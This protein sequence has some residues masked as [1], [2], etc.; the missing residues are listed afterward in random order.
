MMGKIICGGVIP[1]R[2]TENE[3]EVLLLLHK[4]GDYWGFPKGRRNLGETNEETAIR[5]LFEETNLAIESLV[6]YPPIEEKFSFES[7]GVK[8]EK[9]VTYY[10][11][12]VKGEAHIENTHEIADIKW[13]PVSQ[14]MD[15]LTFDS[16]KKHLEAVLATLNK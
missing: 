8:T 10:P 12:F 14:A 11:A 3:I 13:M 4:N 6:D 9:Q 7:D 16:S 5:E 15:T 2:K 1:L